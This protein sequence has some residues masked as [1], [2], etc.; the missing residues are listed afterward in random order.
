MSRSH[1]AASFFLTSLLACGM[2]QV[3][4]P[5]TLMAQEE[6]LPPLNGIAPQT[7]D[8]VWGDYDPEDEPM[9]VQTFREWEED[10]IVIRATR[11]YI[12]TFKGKKAWMAGL[13]AFPKGG[14]NLPALLQ[15]H[16]GGGSASSHECVNFGRRGYAT[17]SLSWRVEPRYLKQ[18]DLPP[19]AQTDWGGVTADQVP[20]AMGIQPS[21]DLNLDPI[22]SGRNE[23][24]FLRTLA[25][26]RGITFLAQ[27]PE[28]DANRIGMTG[29]S[30]GGVITHQTTAMEPVR[31][32]ASA[33]SDGPPI[34]H[35]HETPHNANE[36][37]TLELTRKTAAPACYTD[38]IRVP[39]LFLN[40]VND[41]H[42][43]AEDVEWIIDHLP[44][45][46]YNIARTPHANH[47]HNSAAEAA[48]FLWFDAHLKGSFEY[49]AAPAIELDLNTADG[50]PVATVIPD[51]KSKLEIASVDVYYT[52]DG[53]NDF[54]LGYQSRIWHY[55]KSVKSGSGYTARI[56]LIDRQAP[57]WVYA[58]VNYRLPGDNDVYNFPTATDVFVCSTQ[59][60]M[61]DY[62]A[63]QA[64][65]VRFAP[66]EKTSV[67][68]HFHDDWD[69]EWFS[70][71]AGLD[72]ASFKLLDPR[73]R[74]PPQAKL[75]VGFEGEGIKIV[76]VS[77]GDYSTSV[78]IKDGMNEIELFPFQLIDSKT[79]ASIVDWRSVFNDRPTIRLSIHGK[80]WRQRK[81]EFVEVSPEEFDSHRPDR[82]ANAE[83]TGARLSLTFALA[84]QAILPK[85]HGEPIFTATRGKATPDYETGLV[86]RPGSELR[87]FLNQR[88][89][90]FQTTAAPYWQASVTY[91]IWV[92]GEKQFESGRMVGK[93]NPIPVDL[94]VTNKR[95]LKLI[96]TDAG[97][98]TGGD[99]AMW[100]E[101]TLIK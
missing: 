52:R 61:I 54:Y 12:G 87:Y 70:R 43:H 40:S 76:H 96:V 99:L 41:F 72:Y 97:N 92:D 51:S 11:Y 3:F 26:R 79:Q 18:Y 49:P 16:G 65:N 50:I 77:I 86:V 74:I 88:F 82:L 46:A 5:Q 29:H 55:A 27:Q 91:E 38:R 67:V 17:F 34:E 19:E 37:Q 44:T 78:P 30:M 59:M 100:A 62:E 1:T 39:M 35:L 33:P 63:L 84:E 64:A 45:K 81:L 25:A 69:K 23:G 56:P 98:G 24:Y 83:T 85:V 94:D 89:K 75:V 71:R 8:E 36:S 21:G 42:G 7:L 14:K 20:D 22:P 10:G 48:R 58:D 28:V 66:F 90:R 4:V 80:S 93:S 2:S 9:E 6:S 15:S 47:W 31:L 57:L 95:E 53:N 73:L 101:P 32:K 60:P 68:E 13:Y